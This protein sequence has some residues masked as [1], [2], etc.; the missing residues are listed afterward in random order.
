MVSSRTISVCFTILQDSAE[1][2]QWEYSMA[3]ANM[4]YVNAH[5]SKKIWSW[6][7]FVSLNPKNIK[8][9]L[10]KIKG[11]SG[12]TSMFAASQST[13]FLI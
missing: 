3:V 9:P 1:D 8:F 10:C 12:P 13:Q 4:S 5:R 6:S 7:K 11:L 2:V